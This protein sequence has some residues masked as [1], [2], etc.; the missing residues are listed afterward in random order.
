MRRRGHGLGRFLPRSSEMLILGGLRVC[1]NK[2]TLGTYVETVAMEA[3]VREV[4]V[5][6][7]C[8]FI[9]LVDWLPGAL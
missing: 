9:E 8:L 4:H 6:A 7:R 3:H 1:S 5:G 2:K